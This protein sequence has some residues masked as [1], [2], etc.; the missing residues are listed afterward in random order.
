MGSVREMIGHLR[1]FREEQGRRPVL[2][3]VGHSFGGLL[4]YSAVAQSL[5]ETA[6]DYSHRPEPG[7]ANLILLVNPAFEAARYLPIHEQVRLRTETGAFD[8]NQAAPFFVSVTANNDWATGRLFRRH[9]NLGVRR[10][11]P[12]PAPAPG[13]AEHDGSHPSWMKT[14]DLT[15]RPPRAARHAAGAGRRTPRA[16]TAVP[17][18]IPVAVGAPRQP[19]LGGAGD[20]TGASTAIPVSGA[21]SSSIGFLTRSRS[22]FRPAG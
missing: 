13:G 12:Q 2:V 4:V 18:S 22:I 9:G 17:P 10:K 3:L 15:P 8:P 21:R 5:I 20:E 6:S 11:R 1:R 19:V 7:F 16:S 14:H